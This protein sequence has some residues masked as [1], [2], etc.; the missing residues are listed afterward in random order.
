M[1]LSATRST[2]S[3]KLTPKAE[4]ALLARMLHREGYNDH[5]FGHITYRQADGTLL[6]NPYHLTWAEICAHDVLRI[7]T[8]GNR[9][10][11]DGPVTSSVQLHLQLYRARPDVRVA[12]HHHPEWASVWAALREVPPVFDQLG[13]VIDEPIV[14]Y[15]EYLGEVS[16]VEIARR[17]VAAMGDRSVGLLANHGVFVLAD[18]VR[19]AHELAVALEWRSRL[20]WRVRALGDPPP[21]SDAAVALLGRATRN[22]VLAPY[23]FDAMVRQEIEADPT[24][25]M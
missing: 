5:N 7:D 1:A 21:M 15:D 22:G 23:F 19:R 18:S 2:E 24:V 14:V 25:V 20:A 10:E 4:L 17:N 8:E 9:L 12:L 3:P 6:L 16:D 11:G 13:A